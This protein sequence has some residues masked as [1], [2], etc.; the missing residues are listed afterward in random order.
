MGVY[1]YVCIYE[2]VC[3]CP[4]LELAGQVLVLCSIP[5]EICAGGS[6]MD[7]KV[8]PRVFDGSPLRVLILLPDKGYDVMQV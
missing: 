2:C 5:Y 1:V 6:L 8:V 3:L 4:A 7:P